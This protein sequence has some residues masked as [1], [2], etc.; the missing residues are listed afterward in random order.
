MHLTISHEV[1][2]GDLGV[3]VGLHPFGRGVFTAQAELIGVA[4]E[5]VFPIAV[6]RERKR[7]LVGI[8]GAVVH[9]VEKVTA[10]AIDRAAA[11]TPKCERVRTV[12]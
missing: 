4:L 7:V 12:G 2:A 1:S 3:V 11:L 9:I 5:H 6:R 10:V 8:Y